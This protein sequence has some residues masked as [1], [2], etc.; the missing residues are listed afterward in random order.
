MRYYTGTSCRGSRGIF[1]FLVCVNFGIFP[2]WFHMLMMPIMDLGWIVPGI[3]S[4]FFFRI[5]STLWTNLP[6]LISNLFLLISQGILLGNRYMLPMLIIGYCSST[7]IS[8]LPYLLTGLKPSSY[9]IYRLCPHKDTLGLIGTNVGFYGE[10]TLFGQRA[11]C[12][13][14][15]AQRC[16]EKPDGFFWKLPACAEFALG[17]LG[18]IIS[19]MLWWAT[20]CGSAL[21]NLS[22]LK[23]FSTQG[24]A[25]NLPGVV[26]NLR[27][28]GENV[29]PG[30][31][32]KF[33]L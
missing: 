14:S 12:R 29:P 31:H 23:F 3:G 24:G 30:G 10:R 4:Y 18:C 28:G 8:M 6:A 27:G 13:C 20:I 5:I 1:P 17:S 7:V 33:H 22:P 9:C 19:V 15:N 2:F 26:A 25:T 11:R 16:A 21:K 32:A